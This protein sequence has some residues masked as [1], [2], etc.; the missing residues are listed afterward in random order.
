LSKRWLGKITNPT[1]PAAIA[2]KLGHNLFTTKGLQPTRWE[3]FTNSLQD[4]GAKTLMQG[5]GVVLVAI[6]SAFA[7]AVGWEWIKTL[8]P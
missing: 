3:R 4:E 6:L 5:A 7:G 1:T 8:I 2:S